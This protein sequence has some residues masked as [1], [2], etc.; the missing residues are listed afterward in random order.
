MPDFVED[1]GEIAAS[2]RKSEAHGGPSTDDRESAQRN[3]RYSLKR[4]R[5]PQMDRV[6]NDARDHGKPAQIVDV[7]HDAIG[8]RVEGSKI[9]PRNTVKKSTELVEDKHPRR[10]R[11]EAGET[12]AAPRKQSHDRRNGAGRGRGHGGATGKPTTSGREGS[13]EKCASGKCSEKCCN[14]K[15]KKFLWKILKCFGI[16]PKR[17]TGDGERCARGQRSGCESESTRERRRGPSD[18]FRG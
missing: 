18:R 1:T 8:A 9:M 11:G 2:V 6:A 10:E 5:L 4:G 7:A 16:K 14:C 17:C 15:W 12:G 13:S 3:V